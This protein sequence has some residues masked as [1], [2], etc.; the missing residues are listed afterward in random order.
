MA[1][2]SYFFDFLGHFGMIYE[3]YRASPKETKK[4][5]RWPGTLL[6]GEIPPSG[7]SNGSDFQNPS[8][9]TGR[10]NPYGFL[11]RAFRKLD[12]SDIRFSYHFWVFF[13]K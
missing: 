7:S 10:V 2:F 12:P 11:T 13:V 5:G 6:E 9:G 1:I 8:R 3:V 4:L